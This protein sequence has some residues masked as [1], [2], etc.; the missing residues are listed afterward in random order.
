[1]LYM[2]VVAF[3]PFRGFRVSESPADKEPY[4]EGCGARSELSSFAMGYIRQTTKCWLEAL[5]GPY[6]IGGD[7]T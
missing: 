4:L 7:L 6:I 5:I 3:V 2:S 1:M